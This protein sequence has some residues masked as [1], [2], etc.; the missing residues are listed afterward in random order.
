MFAPLRL[1]ASPLFLVDYLSLRR[2]IL[3]GLPLI[4]SSRKA[5]YADMTT[6]TGSSVFDKV[7]IANRGEIAVRIIRACHELGVRTVAVYSEIDRD[8]LHVQLAH[9]ACL[10]GPAPANESYLRGD[11]ILRVAK[12]QGV[13]AVHPGYGFLSENADFAE[14]V[15]AAGITWI[16]PPASAIRA[17]GS[18][19]EARK[20]MRDAGVP[21]VP[22]TEDGVESPEEAAQLAETIGYPILIKAAMGG[23]GKGMRIVRDKRD[24]ASA[25]EGARRESMNAF[26]SPLIYLEKYLEKPRHIEFQVFADHQGNVIHLGERE[27]SIQRRHQKVIEEA[28]S[29]VMTP[30]LRERM[31]NSAVEAARA[32]GYRNAGTVE[33]LVDRQGNYYFLE[34]NT[35]LQVEHP[36]TEMVTGIDLCQLQLKI[37][38]G[39]SLPL[40]QHQLTIRGHAIE[41][42]IYSEDCLNNF[43]PFTGRIRYLRPPDGFGVREDSGV[44]EGDEIS[45]HYDPMISKLIVWGADRESAINRMSR[46][47]GEYRITGVRTTI[48]FGRLV[49]KNPAF[50]AG[51]FDTSFVEREFDLENLQAREHAWQKV[52]AVAAAWRRHHERGK[53]R[54]EAEPHTVQDKSGSGQWKDVGRRAALR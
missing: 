49:M 42:R 21:V 46:A 17:M 25:L 35:R 10:I 24:L 44:R 1:F 3:P 6:K 51:E 16:G 13:Q 41:F 32:C 7:L 22:G 2:Y 20:I 5:P 28:P 43:L 38:S 27:C 34:M 50:R 15:E 30:E 40:E 53:G 48:P 33:F 14:Q 4:G 36:V 23:G 31:G 9:E 18:K 39:E 37:A 11:A 47:L 29:P 8:S 26:G 52:A 54:H 19:T 45:I 12:E